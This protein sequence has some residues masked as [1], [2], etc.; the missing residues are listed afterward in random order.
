VPNKNARMI[1][2]VF[3]LADLFLMQQKD[4]LEPVWF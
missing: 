1:A 4:Y 3:V 2:G